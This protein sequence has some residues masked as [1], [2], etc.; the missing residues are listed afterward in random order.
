MNKY[1]LIKYLKISIQKSKVLMFPC[2]WVMF[3]SPSSF[4]VTDFY[5][6]NLKSF[7][8]DI[9]HDD[10]LKSVI[11]LFQYTEQSHIMN[12][13][14]AMNKIAHFAFTYSNNYS[15]G[16]SFKHIC[17]LTWPNLKYELFSTVSWI[18]SFII[19]EFFISELL[20]R[21]SFNKMPNVS[22]T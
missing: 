2:S 14:P 15:N 21:F 13:I 6:Y 1:V 3:V 9:I 12:I 16:L 8:N 10:S 11:I 18:F 7:W 19:A 20:L 5:I 4:R 22:E 17:E